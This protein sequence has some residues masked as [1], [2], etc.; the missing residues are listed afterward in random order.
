VDTAAA[1][2]SLD[3]Q[4]LQQIMLNLNELL[5]AQGD[6]SVK[7]NFIDIAE[8]AISNAGPRLSDVQRD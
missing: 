6:I 8:L 4:D 3:E 2:N 7:G 5:I 1:L